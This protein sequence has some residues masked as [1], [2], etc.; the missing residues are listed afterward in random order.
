MRILK[1]LKFASIFAFMMLLTAC[2]GGGSNTPTTPNNPN[3]SNAG[4]NSGNSNVDNSHQNISNDGI[5]GGSNADSD[6]NSGV[7]NENTNIGS[8]GSINAGNGILDEQ[9]TIQPLPLP[10]RASM[11]NIPKSGGG[12]D[13]SNSYLK[14]SVI[15]TDYADPNDSNAVGSAYKDTNGNNRLILNDDYLPTVNGNGKR[16]DH[17][18]IVSAIVAKYNKTSMIYAYTA[19]AKFGSTVEISNV[20]LEAAYKSGARIFNN[21]WGNTR[22]GF[23]QSEYSNKKTW[24]D[25]IGNPIDAFI[26]QK[27][28]SDSIFIFAAGNEKQEY[29][30]TQSHLPVVYDNARKGFIVVTAISGNQ[31]AYYANKLGTLAQYWGIASYGSQSVFD[32]SKSGS[33]GGDGTSFSA[34]VV[35]AAVANVWQKYP[36][37]SNHLVTQTILSTAD[38]LGT[39]IVT[40]G[41]NENVGWGVLNEQRALNGPARFDKRLL[42]NDEPDFVVADFSARNYTDLSKLTFSNDITGDAGFKKKGT[43]TL[44]F[45]GVNNY[46]GNTI[47][48]NGRLVVQNKLLKS[49]V[50]IK[51]QGI[52]QVKNENTSVELGSDFTNTGAQNY[53]LTNNGTLEVYGRGG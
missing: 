49:N 19:K 30:T 39:N 12:F 37:M 48:E 9:N 50:E 15:D 22:E 16:S 43:G 6:T 1:F 13:D 8:S 5:S 29:A 31:K 41:P 42:T 20:V 17:G 18:A 33:I 53:T 27:A 28:A 26:A 47:I 4:A 3:N 10:Q 25:R 52:F 51:E 7:S 24:Q 34:P 21:S 36:W 38:Q 46:E 2:M 44:Y 11:E 23:S 45:S 35:S 14:I 32:D 40:T